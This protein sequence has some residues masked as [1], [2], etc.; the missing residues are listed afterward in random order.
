[1]WN[2]QG[3]PEVARAMIPSMA[4]GI[5]LITAIASGAVAAMLW[6]RRRAGS[7]TLALLMTAIT[8]WA[9]TSALEAG[10]VGLSAK[11]LCSKFEY[12]GSALTAILYLLFALRRAGWKA[13]RFSPRALSLWLLVVFNFGVA[14]TNDWHRLLWTGYTPSPIATNQVIYER[15]P[16]FYVLISLV[17][18]YVLIGTIVLLRS[19]V[20]EGLVRKRQSLVVVS[21]SLAPLAAGL[22]YALHPAWLGGMN[23]TPMGFSVAGMIFGIGVIGLRYFDIAP[24]ARNALF[25]AMDDGVLVLD[26]DGRIADIN[27]A[28]ERLLGIDASHIGQSAE[29]PLSPWP[30]LV[31]GC[32]KEEASRF[33][34][35]LSDAPL[36]V[37]DAQVTPVFD[38]EQVRSGLI[39]VLRDVTVRTH[40]LR[41][42]QKAH[43][44]LQ[45]QIEEI[46]RLQETVREQAIHDALTGL[47]NRRYLKETLP[48]E[49]A[50]ARRHGRP[51]S[52]IL[53]DVDRF[54][55]INDTFGHPAGDRTLQQLAALLDNTTR[56]GDIACRYGGDEFVLVLPDTPLASAV[57]K[58]EAIRS[59]CR[60]RCRDVRAI[61]EPHT[62]LSLGVASYPDHG[63]EGSQILV[64]ADRALYHAKEQGRDQVQPGWN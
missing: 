48:R 39:V 24:T 32:R 10:A 38:K 9:L 17:F 60:A 45:D 52:V 21:A 50:T 6:R 51:L 1:M 16:L 18:L 30:L 31:E 36:R 42:L 5:L 22:L 46:R 57:Q 28:T 37:V 20:Q 26:V 54:K 27:P 35:E 43:D 41:D 23:V 63:H 44:Q 7:T 34:I 58:A 53:L 56:E 59:E 25:E 15:G 2:A 13:P 8:V 3:S 12:L 47:F 64:A 61:D 40:A 29:A 33:E 62:T 55:T 19:T 49:L 14:L 11:I 4:F